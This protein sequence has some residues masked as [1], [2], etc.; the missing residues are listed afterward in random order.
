MILNTIKR[1]L[2]DQDLSFSLRTDIRGYPGLTENGN[3]LIDLKA[4]PDLDPKKLFED[5]KAQPGILDVGIFLDE[6]D[7]ILIEKVDGTVQRLAR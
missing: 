7:E 6:A 3:L 2:V 5:L 4:P 1:W